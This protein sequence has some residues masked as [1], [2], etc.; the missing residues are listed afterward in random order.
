[1]IFR[2]LALAAAGAVLTGCDSRTDVSA[3]TPAPAPGGVAVAEPP[4]AG[5]PP[6][7]SPVPAPPI[8]IAGEYRVAGVDGGDIDLP[9]GISASIGESRIEVSSQCVEMAWSYRFDGAQLVTEAIPVV[10]CDRGRYPEEQA[11]EAA[12]DAARGVERT[13]SNGIRFSGGGRSVL[14][15]SQ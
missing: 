7:A 15:F 4:P 8:R 2:F 13:E 6:A 14:L 10:S 5:Q 1:M 11:I 9:H 12:F 3:G